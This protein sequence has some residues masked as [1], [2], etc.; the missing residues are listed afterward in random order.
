MLQRAQLWREQDALRMPRGVSSQLSLCRTF[1]YLVL[2]SIA[3][4]GWGC[5]GCPSGARQSRRS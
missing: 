3:P 4:R 1:L 5:Q 2:G